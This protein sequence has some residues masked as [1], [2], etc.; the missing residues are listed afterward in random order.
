MLQNSKT[1]QNIANKITAEKVKDA[2]TK[3]YK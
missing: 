2:I 3:K 1:K